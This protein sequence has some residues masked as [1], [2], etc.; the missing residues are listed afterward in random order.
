MADIVFWVFVNPV[1]LMEQH[2]NWNNEK[3]TGETE[4]EG[5]F[6]EEEILSQIIGKKVCFIETRMGKLQ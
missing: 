5:T 3:G 4:A 6:I 2:K 1:E